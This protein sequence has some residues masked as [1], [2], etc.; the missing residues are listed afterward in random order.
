MTDS[1]LPGSLP[2][3]FDDCELSLEDRVA[4]FRLLAHAADREK[5]LAGRK[6]YFRL[7]RYGDEALLRKFLLAFN[8]YDTEYEYIRFLNDSARHVSSFRVAMTTRTR[9]MRKEGIHTCPEW[10]LW[11]KP[12]GA[13]FARM[14]GVPVA[15]QYGV[16]PLK[17]LPLMP[18]RVVKP[19]S[20]SESEGVYLIF[21]EDRICDVGRSDVFSGYDAM[22]TRLHDDLKSGRAR[23]D[24]WIVEDLLQNTK[25]P[26][27]IAADWK[28]LT[29][30]GEVS[31]IM[32][33]RRLPKRGSVVFTPDGQSDSATNLLGFGE[34][35]SAL[36]VP[37]IPEGY[38][39]FIRQISLSVPT[40][41]LRIDLLETDQGPVLGEFTARTRNWRRLNR[42]LDISLGDAFSGAEARL[43]S[44]LLA[45]KEFA[46][47]KAFY[48]DSPHRPDR[49][50]PG[51]GASGES[52]LA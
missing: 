30:Y 44:D 32:Y 47:W 6:L 51:A 8:A 40:P 38:T 2:E 34:A 28:F 39:E 42:Q 36:P 4:A 3:L 20:G 24:D 1:G 12:E 41:C 27:G 18:K 7:K 50:A 19:L 52:T 31:L 10:M 11:E 21:S 37:A 46:K 35:E 26:F 15:E 48:A 43:Q 25:D 17:D 45:G 16:F 33:L 5:R 29:F 9:R 49:D 23:K 22:R 13:R 14:L